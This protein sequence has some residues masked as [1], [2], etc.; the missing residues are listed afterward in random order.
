MSFD[1]QYHRYVLKS[2]QGLNALSERTQMEGCLIR[3][4]VGVGCIHPWV[5]L[6]DEPLQQQLQALRRDQPLRLGRRALQCASVDGAAREKGVSLFAGLSIPESHLTVNPGMDLAKQQM[7]LFSRIKIKGT[8]D[9]R[10]TREKAQRCLQRAAPDSLLRLDFNGC[11]DTSV[12]MNLAEMLGDDICKRIEFVE[13][14]VKYEQEVWQRLRRQTGLAL[15]VDRECEQAIE[16]SGGADCLVFKPAVVDA[17]ALAESLAKSG[18]GEKWV[19]TSYMDHA[20]GQMF[21]AYQAAVLKARFPER[22]AQCG[23]LTHGLFERDE[24][25]ESVQHEGPKLL[26]PEGTGLGFD[27]QLKNLQWESL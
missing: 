11:L 22:L 5:E 24:F 14:P 1:I 21:A 19:V 27:E 8:T 3:V 26:V 12:A 7:G 16:I 20:M 2:D 17:L 18:G 9:L 10:A 15:A 13:D 6:G 23:L 25:F 4:G